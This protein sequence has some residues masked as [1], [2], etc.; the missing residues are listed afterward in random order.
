MDVSRIARACAV[1]AALVLSASPAS[2]QLRPLEPIEWRLFTGSAN[3]AAELG[4]SRLE[5]QRASLAGESGLLWE[6]AN[7]AAAWKTGRV[8]L[9]AA[10]T[11][12][13]I[14][15]ARERFEE[16]YEDVEPSDDGRRHDSGDYRISTTVRLTPD[17]FPIT[18][19][20]RFG[21]R[22][23]TT[24]NTTGLDRDAIDFFATIGA[25]SA[26]GPLDLSGEAGLGI[27]TTRERR[28]EQDDLLLYA[29]R[30][31]WTSSPVVPSI[32]LIGQA[33]SFTAG[34]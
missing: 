18:G 12:Q 33:R 32:A 5:D 26:R 24:D 31:E 20:V 6:I 8:V 17:R 34:S 28:F 13:R 10:G 29:F 4:T 16:P 23:P 19:A 22:L 25:A 27:H 7:F 2:A 3:V 11:G 15:K 14:F 1:S 21:T 9:E 30:A